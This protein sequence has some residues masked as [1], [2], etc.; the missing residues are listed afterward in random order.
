MLLTYK[1]VH[2]YIFICVCVCISTYVNTT[3]PHSVHREH[4]GQQMHLA[5]AL[6][7][8]KRNGNIWGL[9]KHT[10]THNY[11]F[12]MW[13]QELFWSW[14]NMALQREGKSHDSLINRISCAVSIPSRWTHLALPHAAAPVVSPLLPQGSVSASLCGSVI[15]KSTG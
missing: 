12:P 1:H 2:M 3:P 5:S 13:A 7:P 6:R 9:F 14:L 10:Q 4:L 15:W 8:S 11:G